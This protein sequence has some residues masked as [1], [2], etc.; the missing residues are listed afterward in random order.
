MTTVKMHA[1]EAAVLIASEWDGDPAIG[2]D[3]MLGAASLMFAHGVRKG[4]QRSRQ[5][6]FKE[7]DAAIDSMMLDL[8]ARC[9]RALG[10]MPK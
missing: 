10:D 4:S 9:Y 3:I 1:E 2:I 5:R 8:R 6:N 7:I